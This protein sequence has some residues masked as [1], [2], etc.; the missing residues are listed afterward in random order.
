MPMRLFKTLSVATA[1]VGILLTAAPAQAEIIY[2]WC[3]QYSG[4]RHGINALSCDFVSFAQCMATARGLGNTCSE[5]P[6]YIEPVR[7]AK[8]RHHHRRKSH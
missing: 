7:S 6:A 8:V 3:V 1:L 4:G 2:P 5:N